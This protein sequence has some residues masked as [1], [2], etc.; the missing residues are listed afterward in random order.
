MQYRDRIKSLS[1]RD[2]ALFVKNISKAKKKKITNQHCT[3]FFDSIVLSIFKQLLFDCNIAVA[4]I[5]MGEVFGGV[6]T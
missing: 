6:I 1:G 5:F 2:P 4:C 3:V